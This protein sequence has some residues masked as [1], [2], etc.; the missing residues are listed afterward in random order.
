MAILVSDANIFIDMD[1]GDLTRP[2]FRLEEAFA[3]PDVLYREELEEHH[4]E[5]L[6]LGLHIERL[7]EAGVVEVERMAAIN[8]GPSTN[9]LFAIALAKERR[10]PLLSGDRR[11]REAAIAEDVEIRGTLWLI[12]RMIATNTISLLQARTA[13]EQMRQGGRRLPWREVE[14]MMVR[15]ETG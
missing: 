3:T 8:H 15:L 1:V 2:M 14:R 11:V 9:D 7:S 12:E 5:L 4:P 13:I 6:G 10:W